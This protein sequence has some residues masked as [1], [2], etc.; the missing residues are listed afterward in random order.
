[1]KTLYI[2]AVLFFAITT[3]AQ[4]TS[5]ATAPGI[6]KNIHGNEVEAVLG[7]LQGLNE[8]NAGSSD[9][10]SNAK[11]VYKSI[12]GTY[13]KSFSDKELTELFAFYQTT[14]GK[15]LLQQKDSIANAVSAHIFE[16]ERELMGIE[17]PEPMDESAY[18]K[19]MDSLQV[20][21]AKSDTLI[22]E[23]IPK[24]NSL[25]DLRKHLKKH[26]YD[27]ANIELLQEIFGANVDVDS[28]FVSAFEAE[29]SQKNKGL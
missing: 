11:T 29:A 27:V 3:M 13:K 22:V 5:D 4:E 14:T 10:K 6:I 28:L 19:M 17:I 16:K 7:Y 15:K 9:A 25:A 20:S 2:T 24:I 12:L 23:A 26:P 8:Q 1:M 18:L 21:E